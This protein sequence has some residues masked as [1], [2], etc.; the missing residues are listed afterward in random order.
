MAA[1]INT[2]NLAISTMD[3]QDPALRPT[4]HNTEAEVSGINASIT[5]LTLN[6]R[7]PLLHTNMILMAPTSG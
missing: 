1:Y 5:A 2:T 4:A 7:T 3:E 6:C